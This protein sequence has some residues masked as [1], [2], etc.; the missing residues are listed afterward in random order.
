MIQYS[1][2]IILVAPV[3]TQ[4]MSEPIRRTFELSDI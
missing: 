1:K 3:N 4:L 2:N